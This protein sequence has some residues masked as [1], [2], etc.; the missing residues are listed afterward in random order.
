MELGPVELVVL[1]FPGERADPDVVGAV[2]KVVSQGYVTVLDLVF[3]SRL[4]DGQIRITD[5]DENLDDLG[6]GSLEIKAQTLVNEDDMEVIR[7]SLEPGTSA[8][9]IVYEESWARGVASAVRKAG[10]EVALHVQVP[11][12]AVGRCGRRSSL[13]GLMTQGQR[14]AT[15]RP[16]GFARYRRPDRSGRRNCDRDRERGKPA[17]SEQGSGE[18]AG[19]RPAATGGPATTGACRPGLCTR[20]RAR[21]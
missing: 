10:G 13:R 16:A 15:T 17:R 20:A 18:G 4:Q 3:I 9:I 2:A 12:D 8:A 6:F 5:V 11:R 21:R 1:T 14:D 19:G 7:D